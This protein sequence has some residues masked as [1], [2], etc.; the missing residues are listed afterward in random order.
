MG[1]RRPALESKSDD[2]QSSSHCEHFILLY[3]DAV[4][5]NLGAFCTNRMDTL[6]STYAH[7]AQ[8]FVIYP[9]HPRPTNP[10]AFSVCEQCVGL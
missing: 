6:V 9:G 5:E 1:G 7:Y 3:I 10:H 2:E 8:F 4:L